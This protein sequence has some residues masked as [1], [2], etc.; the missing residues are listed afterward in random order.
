MSFRLGR[1]LVFAAVGLGLTATPAGAQTPPDGVLL[2]VES[3]SGAGTIILRWTGGQYPY[4][5]FRSSDPATIRDRP[6]LIGETTG[7]EWTDDPPPGAIF[8]Y[9][10]AAHGCAAASDCVSG[11]C[12][13]G[14]CCES[15]CAG[16]CEACD[17]AGDL[18]RCLPAPA[19]TLCGP[20]ACDSPDAARLA[21]LCDGL[22]A[23]VDGGIVAC[24]PYTC[25]AAGSCGTTCASDDDCAAGFT[26]DPV[27]L[28]C[29]PCSG[30]PDPPDLSFVDS[31]CDGIDGDIGGAVFVD[32]VG[33]NDA[34]PGTMAQPKRTLGVAI[35]SATAEGKDVYISSGSYAESVT[36]ADG[37]GLYGGYDRATGWSRS[38]TSLPIVGNGTTAVV[39]S[40]LPAPLM[41]QLL[42]IRAGDATANGAS[43]FGIRLTN[44]PS[45]ILEGCV[46]VAGRGG[47]GG[48][49]AGGMA[50]AAGGNGGQGRSGCEDSTGFG[51]SGCARPAG[52]L[53]GASTCGRPGGVGGVPGHECGCGAAGGT[54]TIGVGG[55]VGGCGCGGGNGLPGLPGPDGP[56]GLDGA[57]G[58]IGTF[59]GSGYLPVAGYAGS[60]GAHGH[61][62]GGGGGGSGGDDNCDSYGSSGGGG[63]GGGGAGTGASGGGGGGGSFALH[64]VDSG[65]TTI[66]G[67]IVTAGG[68]TGGTGGTAGPGGAGGAVGPGGP[69]G[70]S[71]EQ[72]DGGMGAAGGA[73][74][75][76]GRGGHG[77]G[78]AGGPS[79]GIVCVGASSTSVS[80]ATVVAIAPGG[81]GGA[82]PGSAGA[83]GASAAQLGCAPPTNQPPVVTNPGDQSNEEGDAVSLPIVATDP[84]QDP[85]TYF[86]TGLPPGLG[87]DAVT[88][89]IS[90]T[91]AAGST[92]TYPVLVEVEGGGSI[93]STQFQWLITPPENSPPIVTN[94]GNQTSAEGAYVVLQI[95]ATDPEQDPLSYVASGLPPDLAIDPATG[96]I[97]G[98]VAPG[99]AGAYPV[100]VE[101]TGAGQIG[102]AQFQWLV[103]A[104]CSPAATDPPD[105]SFIDSNCDG[106]DGE[107]G[108]AVFVDGLGGNDA[109]PGTM[110]QPKRT[111][112]AAIVTAAAAGMDVY[113][114]WGIYAESVTLADGVG[115]HG[116]YDRTAGWSRS[117]VSPPV[118]GAGTTA[119]LGDGLPSP[120]VLQLLRIRSGDAT[121]TGASTFGLRLSNAPSV[122]I[123]GCVV[124]AGRGTAGAA[125]T[126]GTAGAAGN[127][128]GQGVSGCEDSGFPCSGCSRPAGGL[129]GA[130]ACGRPGGVG[131]VP[132]HECGC[133]AFG[134]TGTIGTGGGVGGCGCGGGNGSPGSPGAAG[135]QGVDGAGGADLGV[136]GGSGYFPAAGF[137]GGTGA[138][139]NGGGGGGGGSGG[140]DDCDSY[141]SS[142]GGGGGGGCGGT[143]SSGGQGGGGSFAVYLVDSGATILGG[144]I[145]TAGGGEGG[146]GGTGG[147]GG[148]GGAAGPG[149]PY[150][151]ATEQDDGGMGAAGGTGGAGGRGGHGG[152]GGGGPSIGVVCVGA[153]AA[154]A[155][156][157]TA[158]TIAPGGAGG[159]SQGTAGAAGRTGDTT[160]C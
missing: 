73:G 134:G 9:E 27:A 126:D 129:A 80:Q 66:A 102:T 8:Y 108:G 43:A 88:G 143:P 114:S 123:E 78:G 87:I 98:T 51:C 58:D 4:S 145:V 89:L 68:G 67:A 38:M 23:C 56:A 29:T 7:G 136:L 119:V 148:S 130:S 33:G 39:G 115:L 26:C 40:N 124:E 57:G 28:A 50:G 82:S 12:V 160:G 110:T 71:G 81:S 107:V 131:G 22:G 13:G 127:G 128:G 154:S 95:Q 5:V 63:G 118:I 104:E 142:G 37:V 94:P 41:L 153:S 17:Q 155:S 34:D 15:A 31:N 122:T 35:A 2:T 76:G 62:G 151:G 158:F 69:Y 97:S 144:A 138:H 19:G 83:S 59:D 24:T 3:G 141:G 47:S 20:A 156:P 25:D 109:D 101:V 32:A 42:E 96:L 54:G 49:G 60:P 159:A 11:F 93:G 147:D 90:G 132:G 85:M 150:G 86:A 105:L 16:A 133:G 120:L 92:G 30:N 113:I 125:G 55:G 91:V 121:A 36:L 6:N 72:D 48:A 140:D 135:T 100:L 77:G 18:G 149:G 152:G 52:G 44:A 99:S 75:A 103:V 64:L 112:G 74:G 70:G 146:A 21:D 14:V 84:E 117:A 61:G 45:V 1:V 106:I 65:V 137:L 79:I 53:A 157:T 111:I 10:I 46:V 139:G 116:G